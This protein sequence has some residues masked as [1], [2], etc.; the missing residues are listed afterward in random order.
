MHQLDVKSVFLNGLLEEVYVNQP[1]GFV[2]KGKENK[3]MN[4]FEM[5]NL[6]LFSYF[7]GIEFEMTR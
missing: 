3:M 6:G 5:S 1:Q 4:E 2:V 7:L